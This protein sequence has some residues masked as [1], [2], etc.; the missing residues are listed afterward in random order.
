MRAAVENVNI[1]IL[2]QCREQMALGLEEVRK[3]VV[4]IEAIESGE[5][6]PTFNQLSI[7]A[8]MYNVPRWVFISEQLPSEYNFA[9]SVPAFRQFAE[10]TGGVFFDPKVRGVVAQVQQLRE[11]VIELRQDFDEPIEPFQPPVIKT[12]NSTRVASAI[13]SWLNIRGSLPFQEWKEKLERKGIFVFMTD[14]YKGWSHIDKEVFRGLS[15]YYPVLPIIIINQ[16]DAR[17]AF[18]FTLFHEL[19]HLLRKEN[20]ADSW[21]EPANKAAEKWCNELAGEVLMPENPFGEAARTEN[22]SELHGIE[23]LA[24]KFFVSTYACLVRLR[25]LQRISRQQYSDLERQLKEKY[26]EQ[27]RILKES[28]RSLK[29]SRAKE[30]SEQYGQIY[31][32]TLLQAY[33]NKEI[34]L[35]KLFKLF[36]LKYTSHGLDLVNKQ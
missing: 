33:H 20:V 8:E 24:R 5:K 18:S 17:K 31:T 29:R 12:Q 7:L 26:E 9:K 27:Q 4:A 1:M 19:G 23:K 35:H 10:Q 14:K 25:S 34:S 22:V 2:R 30:V 16:S 13:R 36:N 32:A 6:Y 28:P 15:I 11:L 3:K 21:H